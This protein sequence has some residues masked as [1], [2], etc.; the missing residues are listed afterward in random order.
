M[1]SVQK[2]ID[3]VKDFW[4]GSNKY[5]KLV[6]KCGFTVASLFTLRVILLSMRRKL[7]KL[8][9]GP[10]GIIPYINVMPSI[11]SSGVVNFNLN[12]GSSY[13]SI[14]N[15]SVFNSE[16]NVINDGPLAKR[17]MQHY[18]NCSQIIIIDHHK[19]FS[20]Q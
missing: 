11:I 8:P 10:I 17:T 13:G 2:V 12:L 1:A 20:S 5:T 7:K 9:P 6:I 3:I 15:Y 14:V 16:F 4:S 19:V 18:M